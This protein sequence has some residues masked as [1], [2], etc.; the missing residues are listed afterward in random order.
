MAQRLSQEDY[1]VVVVGVL[2]PCWSVH[3][4]LH[5]V[6]VT[7]RERCGEVQVRFVCAW[8]NAIT[9]GLAVDDDC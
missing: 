6:D 1:D 8:A 3:T 7:E 4:K 9:H 2:E 5:G